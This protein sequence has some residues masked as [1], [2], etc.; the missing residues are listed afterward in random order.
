MKSKWLEFGKEFSSGSVFEKL[1]PEEQRIINDFKDKILIN[2]SEE[3][4][5]GGVREVLRFREITEKPLD[6][7]EEKDLGKF[8][9]LL[10]SCDFAEHTKEKIKA[11]IHS[12][13]KW[14]YKDWSI[15]FND[16][17]DI[18]YNCDA[19]RKKAITS[20]DV[21]TKRDI[22][23]IMKTETSL[24]WKTFFIVQYEGAF[25]TGEVRSLKWSNVDL[26]K[27]DGFVYI[28]VSSKKNSKRRE[29]KRELPLKEALYYLEELKKQQETQKINSDW[30]FPSP[31]NSN[32]H[33]S[34]AVNL[35][36]NKLTLKALG[37]K[38]NPY[39]LRHSRGTELKQLVLKG[40]MSK[41]NAVKFMGHSEKMF[42][43][44]YSHIDDNEIKELIKKQLYNFE[45]LPEEKKH[46]LEKEL[47]KQNKDI[48]EIKKQ[49]E[50]A[51]K[52][53]DITAKKLEDLK[54]CI[55]MLMTSKKH[56]AKQDEKGNLIQT[57]YP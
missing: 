6:K 13:L 47:K 24:F 27:R 31:L 38:I 56:I 42:D 4:A 43:K 22:E 21:L 3:R 50:I 52:K 25:R 44:V 1:S 53:H 20:D 2:A 28:K 40:I 35:W 46:E 10:N 51:A 34:K 29:K 17:E 7:I 23:T 33:I 49:G 41:D 19:E 18:K 12:F 11:H 39:L 32:K 48:E 26:S 55:S 8:I 15:R 9:T 45:Y 30:V 37:R 14:E 16:F 57:H 54:M 5:K 36:F